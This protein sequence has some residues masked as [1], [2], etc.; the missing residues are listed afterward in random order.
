MLHIFLFTFNTLYVNFMKYLQKE[1]K[2]KIEFLFSALAA[3][4]VVEEVSAS[5][6]TIVK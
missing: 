3:T 1:V 5:K 4:A 6:T 2:V